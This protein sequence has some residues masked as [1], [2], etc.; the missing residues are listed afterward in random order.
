MYLQPRGTAIKMTIRGFRTKFFEEKR[1]ISRPQHKLE[2]QAK[3]KGK[4][5]NIRLH[6]IQLDVSH[7]HPFSPWQLLR[8]QYETDD[9]LTNT[10]LW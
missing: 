4:I 7:N 9:S 3:Q 5:E 10:S 8:S 6:K 2:V 1:T